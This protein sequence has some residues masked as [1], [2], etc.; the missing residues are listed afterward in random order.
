[1][2][3]YTIRKKYKV[4]YSHQLFNAYSTACHET[5]HGHSGIVELFIS[6][7]KLDLTDMVVD[8]GALTPVIK[9]HIMDKYDHALFMPQEFNILSPEYI[10]MLQKYNKKLTVTSCNPTAEKFA[11]MIYFEVAALLEGMKIRH[12]IPSAVELM[13]VR[14]HETDTGF[15]EYYQ[16]PLD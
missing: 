4:E 10:K 5:I 1:M 6:S 3:A 8:F 9:T 11:E 16:S 14:F 12:E 13:K 2:E 15:A 7:P